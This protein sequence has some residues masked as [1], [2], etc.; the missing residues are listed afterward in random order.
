MLP[1]T[2]L[3]NSHGLGV[4]VPHLSANNIGTMQIATPLGTP[5]LFIAAIATSSGSGAM[6]KHLVTDVIG[7]A[8]AGI[9]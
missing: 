1:P 7:I 8:E 4:I 6:E 9:A 5:S 3:H 2:P